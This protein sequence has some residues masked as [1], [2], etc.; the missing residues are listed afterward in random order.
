MYSDTLQNLNEQSGAFLVTAAI[1]MSSILGSASG[2]VLDLPSQL[3]SEPPHLIVTYQRD[4]PSFSSTLSE[5]SNQFLLGPDEKV[6]IV[7]NAQLNINT[8][9]DLDPEI[10]HLLSKNLLDLI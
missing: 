6:E 9:Q 4:A 2:S 5:Y 8:Q 7:H 10:E 3:P 1:T